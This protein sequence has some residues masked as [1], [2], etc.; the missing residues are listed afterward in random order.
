M[1]DKKNKTWKVLAIV[2]MSLFLLETLL[3]SWA[4]IEGNQV[5]DNEYKCSNICFNDDYESYQY[6]AYAEMCYC[7]V[8]GE[9]VYQKLME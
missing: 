7:F 4:I 8:D 6:D 2:F 3:F 5:I 1:V 9:V